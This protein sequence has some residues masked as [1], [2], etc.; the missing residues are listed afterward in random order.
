M[1]LVNVMGHGQPLFHCFLACLAPLFLCVSVLMILA[2]WL[3][4]ASGQDSPS[5]FVRL[6]HTQ[7]LWALWTN[8]LNLSTSP[9][10]KKPQYCYRLRVFLRPLG[11]TKLQIENPQLSPQ[12]NPYFRCSFFFLNNEKKILFIKKLCAIN[13]PPPAC[14]FS[15][16]KNSVTSLFQRLQAVLFKIEVTYPGRW[17]EKRNKK[18]KSI[19]NKKRGKEKEKREE[20]EKKENGEKQKKIIK[21]MSL[22]NIMSH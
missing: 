20:Q 21:Q 4:W 1:M 8:F 6:I 17:G 5:E 10:A 15:Y 11:T 16:A 12:V 18:K 19:N 14:I 22:E 9:S 7:T 3:V 13:L 2:C